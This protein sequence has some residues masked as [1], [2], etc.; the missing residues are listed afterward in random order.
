MRSNEEYKMNR[1]DRAK[2]VA[3]M[4]YIARQVNDE[5]LFCNLWLTCGVADGD[6]TGEEEYDDETFDWYIHDEEFSELMGT[7]LDLM[8]RAY[9]SGGLYCDRVLSGD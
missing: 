6:L 8:R 5:D 4:E 2:M 3:A 1:K 9:K 7:F